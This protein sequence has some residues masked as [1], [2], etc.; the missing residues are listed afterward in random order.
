MCDRAQNSG[1][2][3]RKA[4]G[5]GG[6]CGKWGWDRYW[7]FC[8][9]AGR[10]AIAVRE[11]GGSQRR[12]WAVPPGAGPAAGAD[13]G[14]G[15]RRGSRSH[16]LEAARAARK[17][18]EAPGR[19]GGAG[20]GLPRRGSSSGAGPGPGGAG[21]EPPTPEPPRLRR[22]RARE[23][24]EAPGTRD[25]GVAPRRSSG[26]GCGRSGRGAGALPP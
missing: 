11:A 2:R 1:T 4:L 8:G 10:E 13:T 5:F 18:C 20:R 3:C 16:R 26:G 12:S 14:G 22:E 24:A 9:S 21:S 15:E 7:G 25:R 19:R 23:R 6:A 17:V